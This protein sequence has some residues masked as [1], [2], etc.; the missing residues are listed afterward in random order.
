MIYEAGEKSC[1]LCGRALGRIR[2]SPRKRNFYCLKPDCYV[3]LGKRPI[4]VRRVNAGE[5][6][7][8]TPGCQEF[9][10]A[11]YY[12]AAKKKFF[13]S[14]LC[15]EKNKYFYVYKAGTKK[16]EICGTVLG[17][18]RC[19]CARKHFVCEKPEC[20]FQTK[21]GRFEA[22]RSIRPNEKACDGP[23]CRKMVPAGLY[24]YRQMRFFC[25]VKCKNRRDRIQ[26]QQMVAKCAYC[27]KEVR[28]RLEQRG[29]FYCCNQHGPAHKAEQINREKCGPLFELF[30][31]YCEE[32]V[33]V[34]Y[35]GRA[36]ARHVARTFLAFLNREGIG[37]IEL[38]EP[39]VISRFIVE[40]RKVTPNFSV[41]G[42]KAMF[43]HLT[44]IGLFHKPNP[45]RRIHRTRRSKSEP[46]PFA[47][48]EMKR[49]WSWLEER[50][51]TR[52]KLAV[53][54]GEEF[55]PRGIEVCNIHLS[56]VDLRGRRI[57][58][59]NP[60]KNMKEGWAPFSDVSEQYLKKWLE[61][62]PKCDHD[63]LLTNQRLEPMRTTSLRYLLNGI[64]CRN[65]KPTFHQEGLEKFSFHRLRHSNTTKL[66]R[67]GVSLATNMKIHRWESPASVL[68][69]DEVLDEEQ[70]DEY[71][72]A[73][74][75]IREG[76]GRSA[77][78][79]SISLDEYL[80]SQT[81]EVT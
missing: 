29:P 60:T 57:W 48:E 66:R 8:D 40:R 7:C 6:R 65:R 64:L 17:E 31:R 21:D 44:E 20:S 78:P 45:V 36:A 33:D 62:R 14:T 9:V 5:V 59:R 23:G 43:D 56:D 32:V 16:C 72:A 71:R 22:R 77:A 38:V 55:G 61:E 51:D 68:G 73:M 63:Y 80:A 25:S 42:V 26:Q 52:A 58:I 15:M 11:G 46:R 27:G 13:C 54:F 10:P 81:N 74:Q 37:D 50:G 49:I 28:R 19:R 47:D 75:R 34:H 79:A 53:A 35:R 70:L 1:D 24:P 3:P 39:R 76:K 2:C 67:N 69:Y 30:Q 18:I 4:R 12:S 41:D